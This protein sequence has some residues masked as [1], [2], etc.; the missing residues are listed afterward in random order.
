MADL[1]LTQLRP[2]HSSEAPIA[3]FL[4]N[5]LKQICSSI[6]HVSCYFFHFW[7]FEAL[8]FDNIFFI[9]LLF[10][11]YQIKYYVIWKKILQTKTVNTKWFQVFCYSV[12]IWQDLICSKKVTL[13]IPYQKLVYN[14]IIQLYRH[15]D[16]C[17][18]LHKNPLHNIT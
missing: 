16:Y 15:I 13:N 7:K 4:P 5:T 2:R 11:N 12:R 17:L 14:Q 1:I 8:L 10:F 3:M 9:I 18:K 6:F